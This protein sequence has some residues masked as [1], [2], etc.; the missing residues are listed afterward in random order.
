M[1][2]RRR[3]L[4]TSAAAAALARPALGQAAPIPFLDSHVHVW[5]TDAAFP[6]AAGAH[7]SPAD[8]S[9]EMLLELMHANDVARTVLIQVIHYKWDNSY[10][11]SVLKRYPKTFHGVC[12]VNPEDPAAPDELRRLT[13]E[14]GFR[15]V[16]LSPGAGPGGDWIKGPLMA[17]LWRRCAQLKVPMTLLIPVTRLAELDPLIEANPDLQVVIDHMADCPV[18]DA[19]KL[20][21]LL[22]LAKY[23]KVFVKVSHMWSLSREAYPYA[24]AMEMVK[25]LVAAYGAK[26]LM[27]GTDW[28]ISLPKQSY[29]QTLALYREHMEFLS[30]EDHLQ[31]LSKTV[32]EV[33]PFGV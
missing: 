27:A 12:R 33:W 15:G 4:A 16:R 1:L 25:Q 24:D 20:A 6:F 17:P 3:F 19:E 22:A 21:L 5:K 7:P 9:V 28:P 26:R 29:A 10:L 2:T 23:P 32:E 11:A 8:A 18:G 13:E 14:Q 30:A 31:I